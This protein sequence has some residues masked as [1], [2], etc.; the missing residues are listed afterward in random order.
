MCVCINF[1]FMK[2]QISR[3]FMRILDCSGM[4]VIVM[5]ILTKFSWQMYSLFSCTFLY[6]YHLTRMSLEM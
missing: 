5:S 4:M 3:M 6:L 1:I 2:I